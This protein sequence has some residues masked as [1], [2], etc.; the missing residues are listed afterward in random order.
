MVIFSDKIQL[1]VTDQ[2]ANIILSAL[3]NYDGPWFPDSKLTP[4]E[5]GF[6]AARIKEAEDMI[7]ALQDELMRRYHE[8]E[9]VKIY[10]GR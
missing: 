10:Q 1:A 3:G 9:Q 6:K 5:E 2:E 8:N 7:K 4:Q